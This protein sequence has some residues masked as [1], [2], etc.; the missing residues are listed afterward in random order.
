MRDAF[1][2]KCSS[3]ISGR[4]RTPVPISW[5]QETRKHTSFFS[6]NEAQQRRI[7]MDVAELANGVEGAI[8]AHWSKLGPKE[9][10]WIW[11]PFCIAMA[12]LT[13]LGLTIS[14]TTA[15][16]LLIYGCMHWGFSTKSCYISQY[17][18]HRK[19]FKLSFDLQVYF[20]EQPRDSSSKRTFQL[21]EFS[22]NLTTIRQR[23]RIIYIVVHRR[24][25][26]NCG[27]FLATWWRLDNLRVLFNSH[28]LELQLS[29][30]VLDL[31]ILW[32]LKRG[33]FSY[34]L[35]IRPPQRHV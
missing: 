10:G 15:L 6:Q 16:R 1:S 23:S 8:M 13:K 31:P 4:Y 28:K 7:L 3:R 24:K 26:F 12:S 17:A 29:F 35:P 21:W 9:H 11:A 2:K 34:L 33:H 25:H 20:G 5:R 14:R 27:S 22:C 32:M 18:R 19:I 30:S